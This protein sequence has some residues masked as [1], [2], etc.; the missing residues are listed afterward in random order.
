MLEVKF[1][2][3]ANEVIRRNS[4]QWVCWHCHC[5]TLA[6]QP[7]DLSKGELIHINEKSILDWKDEDISE[8]VLP[9]KH[10]ALKELSEKF[11]GQRTK[12][13]KLTQI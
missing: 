3:N 11:Q 10:L 13:W 6:M 4:W 1:N 9:I 12:W 7:Q 5:Q 8:K 2:L